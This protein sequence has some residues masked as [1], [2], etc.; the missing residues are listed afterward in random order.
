MHIFTKMKRKPI[1]EEIE[2]EDGMNVDISGDKIKISKDGEEVEKKL[3]Y[4]AEKKD[5][6]IVLEHK[7]PTKNQ[8]KMIRTMAAHIKNMV[9]GLKEKYEYE[10]K[11][12][13]VHFPMEVSVENDKVIIKNF[14]GENIP[15]EA[16]ILQGV[17]VEVK[18]EEVKV[19]G[20]DKDKT[21][22]TA[23]NIEKATIIKGKDRRV[24]Q[25]GIYITK[26][27]KGKR[28]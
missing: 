15:R 18:D 24:F 25:D 14:Q 6:K 22:Q 27:E 19:R 7:R 17:E 5:D 13:S 12:C 26:K 23:A 1:K 2:I 3:I 8:K 16:K 11:I 20:A 9:E 28:R 10:M 4:P 21:G